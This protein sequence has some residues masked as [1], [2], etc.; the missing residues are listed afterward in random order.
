MV[1]G[2]PLDLLWL[3]VPAYVILQALVLAWSSG[4]HRVV[5]GLPLVVM[6]PMFAITIVNL[7]RE[8]NLWPLLLLF[9]S[10]LALV[11]VAVAAFMLRWRSKPAAP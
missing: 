9:T 7:A 10:P 8:S 3:T 4:W 1:M 5:A 6:V 2:M 11:Y